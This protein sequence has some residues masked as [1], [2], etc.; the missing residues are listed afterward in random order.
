VAETTN[1][2]E[3]PRLSGV[4]VRAVLPVGELR[5]GVPE[6][7][8]EAMGAFAREWWQLMAPV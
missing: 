2:E 4:P 1:L 7:F 3:L 5:G 8:V 6:A